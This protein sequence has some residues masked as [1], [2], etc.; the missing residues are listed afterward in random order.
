LATACLLALA[1]QA[2]DLIVPLGAPAVD[3]VFVQALEDIDAGRL[4]EARRAL[5]AYLEEKPRSAQG[6]TLM[7]QTYAAAN[8]W[9]EAFSHYKKAVKLDPHYAPAYY[10]K[11][12]FFEKKGRPDEAVN[13][14]RA[15][16]L[17]DPQ[18]TPAQD[19]LTRLAA[20]TAIPD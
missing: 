15:A 19:A 8:D 4:R 6:W 1:A 5:R 18:W 13:E 14:Y 17:C 9:G 11:G 12:Q 3:P 7:G 10:G 2:E 16:A 20:N